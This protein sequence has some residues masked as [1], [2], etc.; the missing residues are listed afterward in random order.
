MAA[1]R[2]TR[3]LA[4]TSGNKIS[5][6]RGAPVRPSARVSSSRSS[7][8]VRASRKA[9]TNGSTARPSRRVGSRSAVTVK[10]ACRRTTWF[11]SDK[12]SSTMGSVAGSPSNERPRS[13]A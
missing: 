2:C 4:C 7:I 1:M 10:T 3:L 13:P 6:A 11:P 8:E 9:A 12:S 5:M